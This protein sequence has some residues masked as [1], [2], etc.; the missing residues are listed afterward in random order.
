[1]LLAAAAGTGARATDLGI[2]RDT[3]ANVE[4]ALDRAISEGAD[5]LITTG[6]GI[7]RLAA[8][9][10]RFGPVL[11]LAPACARHTA[12]LLPSC[13]WWL[14]IGAAAVPCFGGA[15]LS[16]IKSS[17]LFYLCAGGVS[18]GD[19]DFIKPLLERRGTVFFGK[20][21]RWCCILLTAGRDSSS[22]TVFFGKV[23]MWFAWLFAWLAARKDSSDS[24]E[25]SG[26]QRHCVLWKCA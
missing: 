17:V 16:H 3:A 2:A 14:P 26:T 7:A 18:M 24:S 19:K 9:L 6:R 12:G 15:M 13:N 8:S 10:H 11:S 5:V 4:A 20:V 25:G 23:H 21:C 22:G 1:M